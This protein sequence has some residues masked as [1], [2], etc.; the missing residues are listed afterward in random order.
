MRNLFLWY[1]GS[2]RAR[3]GILRVLALLIFAAFLASCAP[4]HIP[5]YETQDGSPTTTG[6]VLETQDDVPTAKVVETQDM[7][8]ATTQPDR[9]LTPKVNSGTKKPKPSAPKPATASTTAQK[10]TTKLTN[11]NVGAPEKLEKE[12]AEDERKER[13]LKQVIEGICRGC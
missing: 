7:P 5:V 1:K 6:S 12:R 4:P 8:A 10:D 2:V 9:I 11:K 13:H 3:G